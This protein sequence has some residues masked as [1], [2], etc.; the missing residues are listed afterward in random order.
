VASARKV[1]IG[2]AFTLYVGLGHV[3]SYAAVAK[4]FGVGTRTILFIAKKYR[5]PEKLR[6]IEAIA[7][8][9]Q[10]EHNVGL[11]IEARERHLKALK[12]LQAK[13]L[14]GLRDNSVRS[15]AES[16][17]AL[18]TAIRLERL[19]LGESTSNA[20]VAV[21]ERAQRE[22]DQLVVDEDGDSDPDEAE[23]GRFELGEENGRDEH[24]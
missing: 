12:I 21:E 8:E 18:E 24:A 4:H 7:E 19:I 17:K 3:R 2:E 10:R 5:W 20:S 15:V 22:V 13:S 6:A 16:T 14:A 1:P 23:L 9:R 11:V